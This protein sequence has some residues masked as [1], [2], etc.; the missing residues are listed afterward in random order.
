MIR[1]VQ[2]IKLVECSLKDIVSIGK[3]NNIR[4]ITLNDNQ[5]LR[6]L[7]GI[8]HCKKIKNLEAKNCDIVDLKQLSNFKH[9][10][11]LNLSGNKNL[12]S[13]EGL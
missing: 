5:H 8:E 4:D 13:L 7:Q 10:L 9:L 2:Q 1:S 6:S 3:F 12:R 11:H